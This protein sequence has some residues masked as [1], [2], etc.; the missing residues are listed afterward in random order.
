MDGSSLRGDFKLIQTNE[1]IFAFVIT[2]GND[3]ILIVLNLSDKPV[4]GNIPIY[5]KGLKGNL[6]K[7]FGDFSLKGSNLK[8]NIKSPSFVIID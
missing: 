3:S 2:Y 7:G 5:A 4:S 1:S 6:I 8:Y